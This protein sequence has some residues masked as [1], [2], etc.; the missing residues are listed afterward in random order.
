MRALSAHEL[1]DA[2]EQGLTQPPIQRA[3][4][5]LSVAS[6]EAPE[7]L[8]R[9]SV[10]QRDARLLTLRERLFGPRLVGLATCADCGARVELTVDAAAMRAEPAAT[11]ASP[12]SLKTGGYDARFR[13]PDSS[14]LGAACAL[15]DVAAARGL[16]LQRCVE[17]D[18]DGERVP[19]HEVPE[20]VMAAIEERMEQVDPQA[21]VQLS[22][23]CPCCA[24]R[25]PVAFD[26]ESFL[27][28][29][30]QAWAIRI[31]TDVHRLAAA[32][33]WR[34][35]DILGLSAWRRRFYLDLVSA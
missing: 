15:D 34:E 6:G 5:L 33:G 27:W 30:I 16:L 25:W 9:L 21:D 1:M 14:D 8:A 17:V 4:M 19:L 10:G 20:T 18:R 29:E 23:S 35:A 7:T 24:G 11:L 22:V 26:I 3:L 28:S 32:Y 13:L 2:W 31:L 12:W